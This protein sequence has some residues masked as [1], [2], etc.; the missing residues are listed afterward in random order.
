MLERCQVLLPLT[1]AAGIYNFDM[2]FKQRLKNARNA[3]P[4]LTQAKVAAELGVTPQ[5]VSGWERGVDQPKMDKLTKL[6]ELLRVDVEYLLSGHVATHEPTSVLSH[7]NVIP[8]SKLF[9]LPDLNVWGTRQLSGG[10]WVLTIEP[11]VTV[12]RPTPLM[13]VKDAYGIIVSD[14]SMSPILE[15]GW[16][17]LI[18]PHLP[19]REGDTCVFRGDPI[20]GAVRYM[21][22]K[23]RH[24]GQSSKGWMVRKLHPQRDLVLPRSEWHHCHVIVGS[25]TGR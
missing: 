4:N 21:I 13:N 19:P 14:D 3:I 20:N 8:P 15:P 5:A 12:A 9:G 23:L 11:V 17:I 6:A 16:T 18:N 24:P 22:A 25:Y 7:D 2:S 1:G 10:A